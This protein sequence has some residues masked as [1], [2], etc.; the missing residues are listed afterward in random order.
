[1]NAIENLPAV[2]RHAVCLVLAFLVVAGSVALATYA[3]NGELRS[4]RHAEVIVEVA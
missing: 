1:M 3:S 2:A 4:A